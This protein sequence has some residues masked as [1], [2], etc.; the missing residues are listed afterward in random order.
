MIIKVLKQYLLLALACLGLFLGFWQW[1]RAND[2]RILE[3]ASGEQFTLQELSTMSTPPWGAEL[4]LEGRWLN[5]W[6]GFL[7]NQ[8]VDNV[9]GV[10][11]YR[12]LQLPTS[13]LVL[14]NLGW[15]P[16]N[17][18]SLLP[19]IRSM[20]ATLKARVKV[21]PYAQPALKL[22]SFPTVS[23]DKQLIPWVEKG[24]IEERFAIKL[25]DY[26]LRVVDNTTGFISHWQLNTIS[27]EKH[28]GYAV[29]WWLLASLSMGYWIWLRR[30]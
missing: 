16:W 25:P 10:D 15:L 9:A 28:L 30:A 11:V 18:R 24:L 3:Q 13:S 17:D 27:A 29:Q 6:T 1:E 21:F 26:E 20:A 23:E 8:L 14:V 4:E 22:G 7:D 19:E 2:K 5:N 12:I